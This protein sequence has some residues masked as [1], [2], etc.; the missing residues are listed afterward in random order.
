MH[1]DLQHGLCATAAG[2]AAA[3][4]T[5]PAA[6][7]TELAAATEPAAAGAVHSRIRGFEGEKRW[8][9]ELR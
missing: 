2:P 9:T 7:A 8:C 3:A 5:E 4:A 6:A 1:R